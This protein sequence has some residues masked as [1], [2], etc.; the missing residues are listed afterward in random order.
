MTS[1]EATNNINNIIYFRLTEHGRSILDA[2]FKEV[3]DSIP[4]GP[5]REDT[6]ATL[7]RAH[8]ESIGPDNSTSMELWR[9]A[10]TFGSDLYMGSPQIVVDNAFSFTK[11]EQSA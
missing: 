9:F 4:E 5:M 2:K 1:P 3:V 7:Q 11:P 10:H 6:T 8:D